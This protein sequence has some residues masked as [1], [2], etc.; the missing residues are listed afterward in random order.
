MWFSYSPFNGFQLHENEAVAREVAE[1]ALE[2][3]VAD[4]EEGRPRDDDHMICWGPLAERVTTEG[5][6]RPTSG[7]DQF[8][9]AGLH[10][11]QVVSCDERADGDLDVQLKI[12]VNSEHH[13]AFDR[14]PYSTHIIVC[15][16]VREPSE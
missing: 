10:R 4:A 8:A 14:Y 16:E 13:H 7:K 11:A 15:H 1:M 2:D 3:A 5:G 6:L 9:A 12:R